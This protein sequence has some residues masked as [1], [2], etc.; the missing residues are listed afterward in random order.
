[1][2]TTVSPSPADARLSPLAAVLGALILALAAAAVPMGVAAHAHASDIAGNLALILSFGGVGVIIAR[3]QPRNPVGWVMVAAAV[4]LAVSTVAGDYDLL[5]Y[6]D[7]RHDLPLGPLSVVLQLGWA[8]AILLMALTVLVFPDGSLESRRWRAVLAAYGVLSAAYLGS[9]GTLVAV[10]LADHPIR[11]GSGGDLAIVDNPTGYAAWFGSVETVLLPALALMWV[12][13]VGRQAL[14]YRTSSGQRRAQLRWLMG[15]AAICFAAGSFVFVGA[16]L[17]THPSALARTAVGLA[18]L[19]V[20]ALPASIGVAIL[21][22]RLYDV[23]VII[24]RTLVYTALVASL[25]AVYLTGVYV[26]GR[27]LQALLGQSGTV[28]VT[29]STLAVAALFQPLRA[30]IQRGVDRRFYRRKYD[31]VRTLDAFAGRLRDQVD[32]AALR[33]DVVEVVHVTIQPS[34]C[35]LWLRADPGGRGVGGGGATGG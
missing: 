19:G 20:I 29:A 33:A 1:M 32:L 25:A 21:R 35:E 17:D 30:R 14:R 8:P 3:R 11:V 15:G 6:R 26:L 9:M 34:H 22:Y 27:A 2:S 23:D 12:A 18:S 16:S 28:A 24:R 5:V 4:S 13:F 31:A 10:A 7:G